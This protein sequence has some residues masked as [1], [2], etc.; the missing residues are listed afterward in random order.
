MIIQ[1]SQ[2]KRGKFGEKL[3]VNGATM[4]MRYWENIP[5][6]FS[7]SPHD[8]PADI[9]GFVVKGKGVWTIDGHEYVTSEGD[10]YYLTEGTQY[11]LEVLEEFSAIEVISRRTHL[12][13]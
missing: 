5:R 9:A 1:G 8:F 13:N 10:S 2:A 6:G 3:H 4:E 12:G 11:G 7:F